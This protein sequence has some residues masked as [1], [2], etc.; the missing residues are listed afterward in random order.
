MCASLSV[1]EPTPPPASD[2][3]RLEN[4]RIWLHTFKLLAKSSQRNQKA[5]GNDEKKVRSKCEGRGLG[6]SPLVD[7]AFDCTLLNGGS[8]P[9][10]QVA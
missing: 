8:R 3:P 10:L 1:S 5:R 7:V 6:H 9:I 2:W 4:N